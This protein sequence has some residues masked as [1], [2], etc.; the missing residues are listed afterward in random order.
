MLVVLVFVQWCTGKSTVTTTTHARVYIVVRARLFEVV[1]QNNALCIFVQMGCEVPKYSKLKLNAAT[2]LPNLHSWRVPPCDSI[3]IFKS[4]CQDGHPRPQSLGSGSQAAK[5]LGLGA[6]PRVKATRRRPRSFGRPTRSC[7]SVTRRRG[8]MLYGSC[9]LLGES[10]SEVKL[11]IAWI[12]VGLEP[13]GRW[14]EPD[15]GED[16]ES[17]WFLG[18]APALSGVGNKTKG[19]ERHQKKIQCNWEST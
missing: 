17:A 15:S 7:R 4:R 2:Q 13:L 18:P 10:S 8:S 12:S 16:G 9:E 19:V 5:F 3:P 14:S 11:G 1:V 6:P